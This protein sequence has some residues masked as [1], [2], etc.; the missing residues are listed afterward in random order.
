[1]LFKS[2]EIHKIVEIGI[3][4]SVTNRIIVSSVWTDPGRTHPVMEETARSDGAETQ[5]GLH[6]IHATAPKHATQP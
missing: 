1:M 4:I 6:E 2:L 5:V 3:T